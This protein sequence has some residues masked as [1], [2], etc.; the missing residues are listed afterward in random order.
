MMLGLMDEKSGDLI[1]VHSVWLG[2]A[3]IVSWH[4]DKEQTR[5]LMNDLKRLLDE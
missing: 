2:E 4:I 5:A 3:N 1:N